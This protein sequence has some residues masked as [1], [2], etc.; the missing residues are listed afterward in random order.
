M[1]NPCAKKMTPQTA[2]EVYAN[3]NQTWIYYVLKKYWSAEREEKQPMYARWH[4]L[5][6]SPACPKGEY[7]DVYKWSVLDGTHKLDHNP[8]CPDNKTTGEADETA[9]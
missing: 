9:S 4:C 1:S 5:V 7:G 3:S 6:V 8:L 2:Y